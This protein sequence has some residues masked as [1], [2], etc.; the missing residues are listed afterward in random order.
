MKYSRLLVLIA[1]VLILIFSELVI[2]LPSLFFT[3]LLLSNLAVLAAILVFI[4]AGKTKKTFDI[5]LG[6]AILP[7]GFLSSIFVYSSLAVNR[8]FIQFLFLAAV[9]FIYFYLRYLYYYLV[10]PEFCSGDTLKN[11]SSFGNFFIIFFSAS[12][13]YGLQSFLNL[14][15]W[16]LMIFMLIITFLA[17]YQIMWTNKVEIKPAFAHILVSGVVLLEIGWSISFLPLNHNMAGL[18]LAICYY[19]L[20]S[21]SLSFL[22]NNLDRKI[23]KQY[24]VFGFIG[25]F[26]VLLSARWM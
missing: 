9:G 19:I 1:P 5:Y 2:F 10:R 14:P 22:D 6:T 17:V 18:V 21:L 23:I 25:I 24:L 12:A 4:K 26:I 15:V 7:L 8:F 20:I 11:F 16:L 3:S 13:I